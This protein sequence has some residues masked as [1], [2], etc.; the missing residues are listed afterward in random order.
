MDELIAV[1]RIRESPSPPSSPWQ[2][3]LEPK[4]RTSGRGRKRKPSKA[5]LAG[6]ISGDSDSSAL[7]QESD[8]DEGGTAQTPSERRAGSVATATDAGTEDIQDEDDAASPDASTRLK[9][10]GRKSA[11][12][13]RGGLSGRGTRKRKKQ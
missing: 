9:R 11:P 2:P 12:R 10:G 13:G 5:N 6:L 8:K 4:P 7:T 1:R 3:S